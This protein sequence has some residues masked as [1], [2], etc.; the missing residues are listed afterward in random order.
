MINLDV[1]NIS[2][3]FGARKVFDNISFTIA[4]GQ[5]LAVIGPNGSGKTTLLKLIIGLAVPTRGEV[6]FSENGKKL[7][8]D[9]YRPALSLVGPYLSL[10]SS[11]TALEN[12]RFISKVNGLIISE[13]EMKNIL[14]L[15]G[16][17]G[18]GDD[19]VSAYSSGMLQRLKYAAA[20][21]KNPSVLILDEPTANLDDNG[22]K[23]IFD[24]IN[25]YRPDSIIIIATNE[26]EEYS[27]ANATCQLGR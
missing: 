7:D 27:L 22:K 21:I 19:F 25:R 2:K 5:S 8:F 13:I 16:L 15:V 14:E 6:F 4:P 24:L 12:L 10:Y 11:L 18:R 1:K 3:W 9:E 20:L 23:V 26:K 17:E